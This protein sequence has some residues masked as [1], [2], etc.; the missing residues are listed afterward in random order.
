MRLSTRGRYGIRAMLDIALH[1][2]EGYVALKS[3]A[4]RQNISESY[5][6]Q[7]IGELRKAGLV[8]SA[9]GAQGGYKLSLP[10]SQITVGA[11]LRTLE[12][13]LAPVDCVSEDSPF[14]CGQS[15]ECVTRDLWLKIRDSINSVIDTV[16]LK[17]LVDK[18]QKNEKK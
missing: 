5:L 10:V 8:M 12:G 6:E 17:D 13:S 4:E 3:I 18:I 1:D 15:E 16:T 11:I 2:N 9:R 14:I 7:L